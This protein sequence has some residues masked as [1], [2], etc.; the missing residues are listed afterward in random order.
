M[1]QEQQVTTQ[2]L[3]RLN[4]CITLTMDAI[5]RVV[6]QLQAL[7]FGQSLSPYL[8]HLSPAYGMPGY[9]MGFSPSHSAYGP[10]SSV[11]DP[12]TASYVNSQ[13]LGL[14]SLLGQNVGLG[15]PWPG[16][17]GV[18]NPMPFSGIGFSSPMGI[19]SSIGYGLGS[20]PNW[21]AHYGSPWHAP[22]VA[23]PVNF[24]QRVF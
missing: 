18:P 3:C 14:R 20:S 5:R 1:T 23:S 21:Q 10:M 12:I 15:V 22:Y 24:G 9:G 17:I 2:E 8:G 6:P 19:N 11:I 16:P 7:P 4:D 13:S